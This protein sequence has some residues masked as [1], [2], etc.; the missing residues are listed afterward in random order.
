MESWLANVFGNFF[1]NIFAYIATQ[2]MGVPMIGTAIIIVLA[3]AGCILWHQWRIKNGKTGV[4]S[5]HIIA[6]CLVGAAILMMGAASAYIWQ[7]FFSH[8][9]LQTETTSAPS[10]TIEPRPIKTVLRLQFFGDHRVP[11]AIS[12]ENIANWFAYFSPSISVTLQ[13]PGGFEV[14]PN[15]AIFLTLDKPATYRQVITSF[16]NPEVM[17]LTEI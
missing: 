8:P 11:Q 3:S 15:W 1:A 2:I 13:V 4:E 7:Q 12:S 17:P 14:P 9:T 10:Q 5:S 6:F 16:S